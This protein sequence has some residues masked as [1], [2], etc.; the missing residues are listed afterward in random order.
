MK[1]LHIDRTGVVFVVVWSSGYIGGSIAA[2]VIAPLAGNLWRFAI[3]GV[4]LAV[5]ARYRRRPWPRSR[6]ELGMVAAL[7]VLLFT[8]PSGRP[9]A[10]MAGGPPAPPRA[11]A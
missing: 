7:G 4:V 2:S 10:R 9:C 6:R 5:I 3:G 1:P 11:P 8:V